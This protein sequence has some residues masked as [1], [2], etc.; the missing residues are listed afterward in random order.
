MPRFV[1]NIYHL[2]IVRLKK[3]PTSEHEGLRKS[4][5]HRVCQFTALERCLE[6]GCLLKGPFSNIHNYF[7]PFLKC[8]SQQASLGTVIGCTGCFNTQ[9][10]F[11][12]I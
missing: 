6:M 5:G 11:Q 1:M 4:E 10:I 12:L 9:D 8:N 7:K 3:L 2:I